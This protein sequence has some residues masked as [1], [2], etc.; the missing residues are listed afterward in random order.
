[1]VGF[2]EKS[3][4]WCELRWNSLGALCLNWFLIREL[5][6]RKW[7]LEDAAAVSTPAGQL[8]PRKKWM[9]NQLDSSLGLE[10]LGKGLVP[11]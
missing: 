6:E 11:Q 3:S 4:L 10:G 8:R 7:G 1:M 9:E 2:P 5:E